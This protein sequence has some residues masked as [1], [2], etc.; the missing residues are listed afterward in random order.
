MA[1]PTA[2]YVTR[3]A[4]HPDD[5]VG[6]TR[7][8]GRARRRPIPRGD[9]RARLAGRSGAMACEQGGKA[10][11]LKLTPPPT[12]FPAGRPPT[13]AAVAT[14][15]IR[16][17]HGLQGS[18]GRGGLIPDIDYALFGG[19]AGLS[20]RGSGQSDSRGWQRGPA[21]SGRTVLTFNKRVPRP[22]R[23]GVAAPQGDSRLDSSRAESA[24]MGFQPAW[25]KKLIISPLALRPSVPLALSRAAAGGRGPG[26]RQRPSLPSALQALSRCIAIKLA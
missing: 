13:A 7:R 10:G 6:N 23:R 17:G 4:P 21:G 15:I 18:R 11:I 22:S 14:R 2:R 25:G 1:G 19:G 3:R 24:R 12:F 5:P 9:V 26:G 20:G 16:G 8:P